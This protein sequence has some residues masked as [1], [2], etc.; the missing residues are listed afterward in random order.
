MLTLML[1]FQSAINLKPWSSKVIACIRHRYKYLN[2][3][4]LNSRIKYEGK[5]ALLNCRPRW[6]LWQRSEKQTN[7]QKTIVPWSL[8]MLTA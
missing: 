8:T 2:K 1:E 6:V 7:K 5:V 4:L 3:V